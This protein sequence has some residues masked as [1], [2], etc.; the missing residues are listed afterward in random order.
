MVTKFKGSSKRPRAVEGTHAARAQAR[1]TA[2]G[3]SSKFRLKTGRAQHYLQNTS[4]CTRPLL[5]TPAQ[6]RDA[7][8]ASWR[9]VA[10]V[11][12][13]T[14]LKAPVEGWAC[15]RR[16]KRCRGLGPGARG[17][18][19]PRASDGGL[20]ALAAPLARRPRALHFVLLV[21]LHAHGCR[22]HGARARTQVARQA[23][24]THAGCHT[25]ARGLLSGSPQQTSRGERAHAVTGACGWCSA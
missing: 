2:H 24:G 4:P 10:Q 14:S 6:Q 15:S 1:E 19:L 21:V 22:S 9:R 18:G 20:G 23:A 16:R 11:R 13:L 12:W 5:C 8:S 3:H 25:K 17:G 7:R